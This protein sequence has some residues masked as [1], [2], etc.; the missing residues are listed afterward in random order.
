MARLTIGELSRLT[1]VKATTIRWYEA[2]GWLPPPART[3]GG[4]RSYGD[5]HLRRLGFI[6]HARELGFSMEHVRSL[7]DL[8]DRPGADCSAAHAIAMAHI[9]EVDARM[10]RLEALR[11]ELERM[12]SLCVGGHVEECRI[13]ETLADF[14]HGHCATEGHGTVE[15]RRSS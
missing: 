4:H 5:T 12:A 15:D 8:A 11:A 13:I 14:G 2:E 9:A 1:G 3:E 7:L 10:R 6:R